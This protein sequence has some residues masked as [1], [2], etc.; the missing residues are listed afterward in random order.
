LSPWIGAALENFPLEIQ[1]TIFGSTYAIKI[2]QASCAD[3]ELFPPSPLLVSPN[4]NII[5]IDPC[6]KEFVMIIPLA[7]VVD[8]TVT[9]EHHL[10]VPLHCQNCNFATPDRENLIRD[11]QK[12]QQ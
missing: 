3:R 9:Q 1:I 4:V 12:Q 7:H 11:H 10:Y 6:G 2:G 5:K 8:G